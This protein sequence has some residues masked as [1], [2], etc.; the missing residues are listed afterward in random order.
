MIMMGV[1][2][3]DKN[4]KRSPELFYWLAVAAV[5]DWL[6]GRT[7]TRMFI[8]M[9]KP[10]ILVHVYQGLGSLGQLA[11]TAAGLLAMIALAWISWRSYRSGHI[12]LPI[13]CLLL[14]ASSV[15][16]LFVPAVGLRLVAFQGL[17]VVVIMVLLW[18]VL[19]LAA[20]RIEKVAVV[21]VGLTML[22]GQLSLLWPE[23]RVTGLVG[24]ASQG[25]FYVGEAL[26]VVAVTGLWWAFGRGA[27]RKTW[28]LAA[29]PMLF[30]TIPQ[31]LT[32]AM[33]GILA[34]WSTG[35]TLY[36]PW[37]LYA[38]ALWLA[39][40]TSLHLIRQENGAGWA[41]LLLVAGGFAPQLSSHAFYGLIAFWWLVDGVRWSLKGELGYNFRMSMLAVFDS[42]TR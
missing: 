40:V 2:K 33:T 11:A 31:V 30:F 9:P 22:A 34:I 5:V 41:L 35:M 39:G 12:I 14:I 36:L 32:P 8:F 4:M 1:G 3:L 16:N 13:S 24:I 28:L 18:Q 26:V 25:W 38:M 29:L 21:L 42:Q 27:T 15:W 23:L 20:P 37:P 17:V 6:V 10:D 19:R 7:L